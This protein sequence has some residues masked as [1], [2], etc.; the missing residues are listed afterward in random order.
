MPYENH[1]QCENILKSKIEILLEEFNKKQR[2]IV[3]KEKKRFLTNLFKKTITH[4][5]FLVA[6]ILNEFLK[7]QSSNSLSLYY[8]NHLE[9]FLQFFTSNLACLD[10][11]LPCLDKNSQSNDEFISNKT[12]IILSIIFIFY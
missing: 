8:F 11:N 10:K 4:N 12:S 2:N 6:Q 9:Y 3:F 7:N 1:V 5:F